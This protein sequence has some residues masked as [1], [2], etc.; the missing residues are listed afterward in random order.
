MISGSFEFNIPTRIIFGPGKIDEIGAESIKLGKKALLVTGKS[1]LVKNGIY[2]RVQ[3]SFKRAGLQFS[4]YNGVSGNPTVVLADAAAHLAVKE[5]CD[6]VIGIG[7]GSV[8]D[9][10]KAA[11]VTSRQGGTTW[12][13][14]NTPERPAKV[15]TSDV[16]P[17]IAVPTTAG[18]ASEAT[19]FAVITNEAIPLKKGMKSQFIFPKISIIDPEIHTKLSPELTAWTGMDGYGQAIEGWVS[20]NSNPA[21]D[22]IAKEALT[23]IHN[24]LLKA[25]KNGSDISARCQ[26]AWGV[27]LSGIAIAQI[28]T[29]LAHAMSFPLGAR[30]GL[31]H[32]MT[33]GIMTPLAIEF[34]LEAAM[35]KFVQVSET[36]GLYNPKNSD[37]TNASRV[38]E[39][40]NNL[41]AELNIPNKL[42]SFGLPSSDIEHLAR[43]TSGIGSLKTNVKAVG[44]DDLIELF[45][46]TM[47]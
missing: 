26:V 18:S 45:K 12:D 30:Y 31:H 34:N 9:I 36:L 3:N 46:R 22:L 13:F 10:A 4:E 40:V 28:E 35:P 25:Y 47:V 29:N 39:N 11:A 15:V 7:G 24:G 37:N 5:K 32:G 38:I 41:L 14:F 43:D 17:I 27:T 21:T 19:P 2:D 1:S 6:L 8:I 42:R 20:K 16:L 23:Q 33:V 44:Y